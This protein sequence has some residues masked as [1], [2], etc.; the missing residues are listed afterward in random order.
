MLKLVL[1]VFPGVRQRRIIAGE[2]SVDFSEPGNNCIKGILGSHHG[3]LQEALLGRVVTGQVGRQDLDGHLAVQARV[4]ALA[5]D[6]RG[7]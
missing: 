3:L 7:A 5:T 6:P 4:H 2:A 1:D